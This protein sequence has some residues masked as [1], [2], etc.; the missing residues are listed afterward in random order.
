MGVGVTLLETMMR[1]CVTGGRNFKD[2]EL[3]RKTLEALQP[4]EIAHGGAKGA[5]TLAGQWA[6]AN[7]IP[8]TVFPANWG[9]LGKLAG[10]A[11]NTQMLER[12][13]PDL[14]VAFPGGDGTHNMKI[15]ALA[16]GIK[17]QRVSP[18]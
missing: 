12:F 11:R 15:A 4:T 9:L 3:L 17:I 8:V 1:I 5:D 6:T 16:R 10:F 14:L 7:G 13:K 2:K 18:Q